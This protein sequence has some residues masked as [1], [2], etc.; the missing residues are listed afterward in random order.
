VHLYSALQNGSVTKA[1]IDRAAGRVYTTQILLGM[2]D[3]MEGQPYLSIPPGAVDSAEHRALALRAAL[4]S[5]VLLKNEAG[6]LP[7]KVAGVNDAAAVTAADASKEKGARK[8]RVRKTTTV[9]FI[10]PHANS[11]QSL[12]S[13]YHGQNHLVNSHSPLMAMQAKAAS[14]KG[15][16]TVTYSRGCN[17]CDFPYGENPGFPNQP[18]PK[19]KASDT[20]MIAAAVAAAKAADYVVLLLGS[21]QTTEA[22]NYDRDGIGLA[23]H[24]LYTTHF[25]HTLYSH[26]V[27]THCTHTL[28]PHTA[29]TALGLQACRISCCRRW[30]E[31]SRTQRWYSLAAVR[32][33]PSGPL[34]MRQPLYT[35]STQ[36]NSA[37][38]CLYY[39][40]Y[41]SLYCAC[42]AILCV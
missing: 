31:P 21:D 23:G 34:S 5:L 26:T 22:E 1:D 10:G 20:S 33:A 19:D 42:D 41:Y 13:N 28:Y 8:E 30:L 24:T 40:L 11:T 9:A 17:I 25:T 7:F 37:V 2:L 27:L 29:L 14:S 3:P 16:L 6:L 18:C 35:H 15:A 39:S 38:S 36:E 12:L 32:S 4:E